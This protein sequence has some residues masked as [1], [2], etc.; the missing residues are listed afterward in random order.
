MKRSALAVAVGA[1]FV[2]PAAQAQIMFGNETIGTVQFY[3]KL[4]PQVQHTKSNG[5]TQAGESVSTLVSTTGTLAASGANHGGRVGVETQNSYLGFRGERK[6]GSTGLKGI[7][8]IEQ[9]LTFENPN[10]DDSI[11]ASR[12]SFVG[13]SGGFGTVKLGHMDTIYKE[14]GDTFSMF[15]IKSGNFVSGSNV[16]SQIGIGR[17]STA[18]FHERATNSIQYQTPEF[19]GFQAGVQYAPDELK[20]DP[21][22]TLDTKLVSFGV[23]YDSKLFYVSVQHERHNDFFGGSFNVADTTLRNGTTAAGVFTPDASA[24]SK[25]S[26]TRFSGEW[27]L[28]DVHKLVGDVAIMEWKESSALGAPRFSKYEHTNWAIGW[29]ARWGGPWRTAIQYVRGDQGE[30]TLTSG[31]CST[32]GLKSNMISAGVAYYFDRQTLLY[33]IFGKLDNGPAAR[34]DNA[35]LIDPARGA[36]ITN[37]AVGV[38]Y[39]F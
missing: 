31:S 1:L 21:G 18:R 33:L 35:S 2:A 7:W 16:L 19:A 25:D 11:W 28:G 12:N 23:K 20:G 24:N 13:V 10:P 39:S 3:G 8:Q 15:G 30:C 38:S 4:Y 34:Y 6:L 36:D 32:T 17:S 14:Y 37:A 22:R 26:A 27:R 5:A 9:S 29:E